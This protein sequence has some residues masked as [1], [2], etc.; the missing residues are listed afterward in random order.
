M[1]FEGLNRSCSGVS[2]GGDPEFECHVDGR[3][4]SARGIF[5]K[6][7]GREAV[8]DA[9]SSPI[10]LDGSALELRPSPGDSA[11]SFYSNFAELV[12]VASKSG[13]RLSC[14]GKRFPLGGHIH[15]GE[16]NL[17]RMNMDKMDE[18]VCFLDTVVGQYL[19][20]PRVRK[21]YHYGELGD[22]NEKRYGIEYRVPSAQVFYT[23]KT[24]IGVMTIIEKASIAWIKSRT[25][26]LKDSPDWKDYEK[27]GVTKKEYARFK[28]SIATMKKV[29]T[30]DKKIVQVRVK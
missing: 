3:I 20:N 19:P 27:L 16:F 4:R 9:F 13:I 18:F 25:I 8:S 23:P 15:V 22:Y 29:Q 1:K 5:I 26:E 12:R 11:E 6:A 10:G 28:R 2:I 24:A 21:R 14:R 7:F 17:G 30:S